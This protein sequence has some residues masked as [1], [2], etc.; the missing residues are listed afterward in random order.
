MKTGEVLVLPIQPMLGYACMDG[1]QHQPL[2]A[3]RT[4]PGQV[5][6]RHPKGLTPLICILVLLLLSVPA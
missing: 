4:S 2:G 1:R 3:Q 6:V 5:A